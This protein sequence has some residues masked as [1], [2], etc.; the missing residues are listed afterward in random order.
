MV[1]KKDFQY[2]IAVELKK[3]IRGNEINVLKTCELIAKNHPSFAGGPCLVGSYDPLH[4][5]FYF[6][7]ELQEI[8]SLRKELISKNIARDVHVKSL[9]ELSL[10]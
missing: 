4:H 7:K 5:L 9:E 6:V 10:Y 1:D 3:Y 8:S 2:Q